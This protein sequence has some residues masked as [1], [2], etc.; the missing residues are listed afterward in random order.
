MAEKLGSFESKMA[1]F[2]FTKTADGQIETNASYQGTAEGFGAV[3]GTITM[4]QPLEE[5]GATSGTVTYVGKALQEDNTILGGIGEGTWQQ[6]GNE[7]RYKMSLL[8]N[9]SDGTVIRSEGVVDN[10]A[11]TLN[12]D[13]Y[14]VD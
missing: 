4:T 5:A 14:S 13:N 9:I 3:F 7:P 8:I 11:M 1:G 6:I 2:T 12:G 10:V